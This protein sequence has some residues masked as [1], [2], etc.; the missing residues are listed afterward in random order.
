MTSMSV[1]VEC[2]NCMEEHV[3]ETD[4]P[5]LDKYMGGEL[6]QRVYPDMSIYEREVLIAFRTGMLWCGA[7]DKVSVPVTSC[8]MN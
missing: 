6:V 5:S 8:C 1:F 3:V 7:C 4:K 2:A